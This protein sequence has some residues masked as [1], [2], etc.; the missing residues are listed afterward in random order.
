MPLRQ[1]IKRVTITHA[2]RMRKHPT[3]AEAILWEFLRARPSGVKFRRQEPIL[4]WIADFYC[5][6]KKLVIEVDGG[7]HS[8]ASQQARDSARD[9]AM[10]RYG[11][12]TARFTNCQVLSDVQS[13][14]STI[15]EFPD[16]HGR[17]KRLKA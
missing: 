17:V 13:V 14:I 1:R 4:G 15:L 12:A 8:T 6:K 11:M 5:V 16:K 7:Y 2:Q 10:A 3:E 9:A